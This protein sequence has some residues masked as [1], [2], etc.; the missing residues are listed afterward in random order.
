MTEF[1]DDFANER[2]YQPN[3][4]RILFLQRHWRKL[5]KSA[6][7]KNLMK[8]VKLLIF[9]NKIGEITRPYMPCNKV[10]IRLSRL[11]HNGKD[12][13][14]RRKRQQIRRDWLA[15]RARLRLACTEVKLN[16]TAGILN[17]FFAVHLSSLR[18]NRGFAAIEKSKTKFGTLKGA[19]DIPKK[20]EG[21]P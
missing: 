3:I 8:R 4:H 18:F 15:E 12:M 5:K 19:E 2:I 1:M 7:F 21:S 20:E 11:Q 14:L 6:P 17:R 9:V 10:L 16:F 13:Q